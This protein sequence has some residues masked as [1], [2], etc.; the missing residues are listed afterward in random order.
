M[1]EII[2]LD[3]GLLHSYI[4]QYK[5]GLPN[6][7]SLEQSQEISDS[8]EL[9]EGYISGSA[10]KAFFETGK[11]EIPLVFNTPNARIEGVFRPGNFLKEKAIT[12]QTEMGKEIISMQLHDNALIDF[13]KYL[14]EKELFS[15]LT[16][17]ESIEGKFIKVES[18]FKIFDFDFLNK[19]LQPE[20]I[21]KFIKIHDESYEQ[22]LKNIEKEIQKISNPKEKN[23]KKAFLQQAKNQYQQKKSDLQKQFDFL[24]DVL[25]YLN[26]ILPT[27]SFIKMNNI[28]APLKNQYL[29]EKSSELMFKFGTNENIKAT[30]IAKV[31]STIKNVDVPDMG[32]DAI[33][34]LPKLL[35]S[36][37]HPLGIIDRDYLIVSP[38]AIYFE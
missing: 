29:R 33:F 35:I 11:F 32:E 25:D 8:S 22:D 23:I 18:T 36:I 4:A 2:Y 7:K 16:N 10:I 9:E 38:I 34:E 28:L 30:L 24:K 19:I 27:K 6:T 13:E 1:K 14:K 26:E 3:T 20:K 31:T 21:M 5:G 17:D 37:L 12:F 15:E